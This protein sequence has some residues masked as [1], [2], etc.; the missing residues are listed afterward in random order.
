MQPIPT[1][2]THTS[3]PCHPCQSR[4]LFSLSPPHL[5]PY[6]IPAA[7]VE[8]SCAVNVIS[9]S[10]STAGRRNILLNSRTKG[11]PVTVFWTKVIFC[12]FVG[13]S[14][15]GI[16]GALGNALIGGRLPIIGASSHFSICSV[17]NARFKIGRAHV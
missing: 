15:R 17:C 2:A 8:S 12:I 7:Q 14:G 11:A 9:V 5:T 6:Q 4:P 13:I 1:H 16:L 3:S 10:G